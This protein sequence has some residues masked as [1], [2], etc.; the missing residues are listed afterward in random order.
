M[1]KN[2]IKW[3]GIIGSVASIIGLWFVFFPLST[4]ATKLSTEE[5]QPP[6]VQGSATQ[7]TSTGKCAPN[8]SA[9]NIGGNLNN[10]PGSDNAA[11][12]P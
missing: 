1:T 7:Q 8:M 5:P 11:Q 3:I 9:V 10:C 12:K 6:P 4:D 2:Q